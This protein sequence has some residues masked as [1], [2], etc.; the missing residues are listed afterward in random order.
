MLVIGD[1][2]IEPGASACASA[3]RTDAQPL[4]EPIDHLVAGGPRT[5]LLGASCGPEGGADRE[6]SLRPSSAGHRP[7]RLRAASSRV[8][9][10]GRGRRAA[11]RRLRAARPARPRLSRLHRRRPLRR[12][13]RSSATTSCCA[14]GVL[15][16]PHSHNPTSLRLARLVEAAR[17]ARARASSTPIRTSTTSSS[18]PTPAARSSSSAS[19]IRSRPAAATCSPTTTTTRSTASAS[20]RARRAR[21]STYVP[22]REP[23]LRLDEDRSAAELRGAAR[24]RRPTCSPFPAQSNFSGVQH[25]LEWIERGAR[26]RAGTSCS[27]APR[28]RPTNR[29]DLSAVSPTSCRSRSTRC[30]ATPPASARSSPRRRRWRKLRRPWF[31]GGTITVASVQGDGWHH[32]APGATG[33]EDGTVDYL[34]L[35][36]VTIGLEHL[37]SVGIDAIHERVTASP[38]GCS[39]EM[40][41]LRHSE[42]RAAGRASSARR[43]WSA[44]AAPSRS[45]C[46]TRAARRTT[47]TASRRSPAGERISLRTGCFCNPGDGEVAHRHHARRHGRVLR[48]QAG[49]GHASA[50]ASDSS[51]T[52]PARCPTRCASRWGSPRTSPTST[53]FMAFAERFRDR[54]PE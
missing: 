21:A 3:A 20:S 14:S 30:S 1:K 35:P 45:T 13:R 8:C 11:R 49:A 10:H 29:L 18:R 23:D 4:A 53:R 7:R 43:T 47:S 25:P 38:A 24:R 15:G 36:A 22:V 54:P 41:A 51:R 32:L 27:T 2:E 44:A 34:G 6:R 17:D 28:S 42:R 12:R 48:R 26:A 52:R 40:A 39:S 33:F 31:A 16:N 9:G 50:S 5:R 37:E 19:P 46:S